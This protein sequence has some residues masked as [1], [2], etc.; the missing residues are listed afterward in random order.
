VG[1]DGGRSVAGLGGRDR[2]EWSGVGWAHVEMR[3]CW[4]QGI[5]RKKN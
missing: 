1:W 3:P 2:V 4:G 5:R